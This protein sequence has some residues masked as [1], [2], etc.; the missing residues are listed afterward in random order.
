MMKPCQSRSRSSLSRIFRRQRPP[1]H[2]PLSASQPSSGMTSIRTGGTFVWDD[3]DQ[4]GRQ[5][6]GEP[7]LSGVSVQ[8]WNT[9]KTNLISSSTTNASGFA[10]VIA[11]GS[12]VTAYYRVRVVLPEINDQF[13]PKDN[14]SAG[15]LDDSDINPTGIHF[16]FTDIITIASNVISITTIDAGII[17]YRTPTPT[18]T[19]T[20]ISITTFVWDDIDQD[21][22]QDPGEPGLPGMTV[23]VWNATKTNLIDQG[24]TNGSGSVTIQTPGPG[25]YRVRVVLSEINDQFSPKDN[26]AAGDLA[27]SDINPSGTN[28]GFTDIYTFASNLISITT[29]DAGIIKYRTPTPTRTPTP[30]NLIVRVWQDLNGNGIQDGGEPDFPGVTV[31]LTGSNILSIYDTKVTSNSGIANLIAPFPGTYRVGVSAPPGASFTLRDQGGS[32]SQDSDVYNS[33]LLAGYTPAF[34]I[35]S[36]VISIANID[37]GLVGGTPQTLTPTP[38]RTPSNTFTPSLTPSETL[39]PTATYT[40]TLTDTPIPSDTPSP[41]PTPTPTETPIIPLVTAWDFNGSLLGW[42]PNSAMNLLMF[43][44]GNPLFTIIAADP[45]FTSPVLANIPAGSYP[46][47]NIQMA[48]KIDNCGQIY[49][50]RQGDFDFAESRRVDFTPIAD[51]QTRQYSIHL[52]NNVDY[53]GAIFRIRLDPGCVIGNNSRARIDW[54]AFSPAPINQGG[55]VFSGD[56][57]SQASLLNAPLPTPTLTQTAT[58]TLPHPT[59]TD[60][61]LPT[62]AASATPEPEA[63]SEAPTPEPPTLEPPTAAPPTPTPLPSATLSNRGKGSA[64]NMR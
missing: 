28:F 23:Q 64:A 52:A 48:S 54:I 21:G 11:P 41:G 45:Y 19:P 34:T 40:G 5:D 33:G 24:V 50:I 56:I 57:F 39:T 22:R 7:G 13:S 29:I 60:T 8:L 16:G 55:V 26:A 38:T 2:P 63:T 53:N 31:R 14:P 15:D 36:N 20:P 30:I 25:D 62:E 37:A 3:I 12:S 1:A 43:D 47:L 59:A 46:Y 18:R 35:A 27:D 61:A 17:K 49:F 58:F 51:G 10:T 42:T 6:P 4:D 9:A 44:A 32:D